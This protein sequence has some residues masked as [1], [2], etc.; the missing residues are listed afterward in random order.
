MSFF[1]YIKNL[2][3]ALVINI[4]YDINFSVAQHSAST[5]LYI[6]ILKCFPELF[7][8]NNSF[9]H[10]EQCIVKTKARKLPM[11]NFYLNL[12]SNFCTNDFPPTDII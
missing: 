11:L 5:P 9:T 4:L 6:S 8:F 12:N 3:P 7:V 2:L 1:D 10:K